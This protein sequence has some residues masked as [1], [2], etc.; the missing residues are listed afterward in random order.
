MRKLQEENLDLKQELE[1]QKLE[2]TALK[3]K[4]KEAD[5]LVT[6]TNKITQDVLTSC[7]NFGKRVIESTVKDAIDLAGELHEKSEILTDTGLAELR[8]DG[9]DFV[10]RFSKINVSTN[11]VLA[12]WGQA[13]RKANLI[14]SVYSGNSRDQVS[15]WQFSYDNVKFGCPYQNSLKSA[16]LEHERSCK[17]ISHE[18]F[19]KLN[20]VKKFSCDGCERSYDTKYLLDKHKTEIHNWKPRACKK[21]GCDPNIVFQVRHEYTKHVEKCHP[22]WTPAKCQ[23]PGCT[24]QSSS[25][26]PGPTVTI[27][28]LM[29]SEIERGKTSTC[30]DQGRS[31]SSCASSVE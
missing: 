21:D 16:V 5:V 14:A 19:A 3:S 6:E 2:V 7:A 10:R 18:A 28:P 31:R 13:E 20:E 30:Q 1:R 23:Y 8:I 17:I 24:S 22:T 9:V 29:A 4:E 12:M 25:N 11:Q 26:L 27:Y 15:L